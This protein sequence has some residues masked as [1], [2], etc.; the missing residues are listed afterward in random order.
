MSEA[1]SVERLDRMTDDDLAVATLRTLSIDAVQKAGSGHPGMPLGAAPMA[2]VL[3]SR[4]LRYDP[5][6]PDWPDR[7]RFVLSAGHGSMLLYALLHLAGYAVSLDDIKA[8][9]QWESITPGHPENFLTPGVEVTT[10]P[11]GQGFANG[12]GMAMAEAFL[13]ARYNRPG[14]K[15]VEHRVYGIVSDGDLMEGISSEASSLAGHLGLGGLIYLYDDNHITIDGST[16]LAFTEDVERRFEAYG[17]QV[18]RVADGNDMEA[19]DGS[20]VVAKAELERPTLIM[21]RTRIGFG[22]PNKEGSAEAHGA[23]LGAEEVARTK[24]N[25]GWP[26]ELEFHVPERARAVYARADERGRRMHIDWRERLTAYQAEHPEA[27][28]ALGAAWAGELPE[29]WLDDLPVFSAADKPIATRAASG[30][31]LNAVAAR[32]P[33]LIGG[34]ADL[35]ASNNTNLSA[36]GEEPCGDFQRGEHGGRNLHFGVREHA[37]GGILNGLALHGGVRPYGATFLI[38][39]DYMRASIRLAALSK[40]AVTYVFTHDSV[41]LGEDGPTHQ[42]IEHLA[43]LRAMPHLQLIRPCDAN[44]TAAAWRVALERK[45]G[46][47]AL[48]LSRQNLPI[49]DR[50]RYA[51]A[52]GLARGAYVLAEAPSGSPEL[53]LIGTGAEVHV[54]LEAQG[55]LLDEGVQAR[56][57][58]MPSW[59]LFQEESRQYRDQVLPPEI[60]AR[61]AVEAASSFGWERWLGEAGRMIGIDRFGGSAPG[62]T[63]LGR[64]GITAERVAAAA[65]DLL[66]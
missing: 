43:S 35:A 57:V 6:D 9:R 44:E 10:G 16:D 8:F 21:V 4:H 47:V 56:V 63:A 59:E 23:P 20:L 42:P 38:F 17:W 18:L 53:I 45:D 22:S 40:A 64:L 24:D 50:G 31:V 41:G 19:V 48:A 2:H 27:A 66:G 7:D 13:A 37:M 26:P 58:S 65:R 39:S 25:L 62:A 5:A 49:L 28:A 36:C 52:E 30:K 61:V 55:L 46:P 34:S 12:V 60:R 15:V 54:A 14:H 11:L 33:T 1:L 51:P 3:W 32:L 29:G